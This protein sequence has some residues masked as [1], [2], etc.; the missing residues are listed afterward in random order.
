MKV[1]NYRENKYIKLNDFLSSSSEI[2]QNDKGTGIS[3]ACRSKTRETI[4]MVEMRAKLGILRFPF[5]FQSFYE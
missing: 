5:A 1:A 3:I 4:V 2:T